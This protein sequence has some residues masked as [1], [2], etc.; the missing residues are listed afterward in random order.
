MK[1]VKY[2]N[3]FKYPPEF[4]DI[5]SFF[6]KK[7]SKK[8]LRIALSVLEHKKELIYSKK[9]DRY[10]PVEYSILSFTK[11]KKTSGNKLNNWRFRLY[12]RLISHLPQVKLVGL[13]GSIS[14]MNA[15]Q[16][17][18]VDLF[19]ITSRSRLFTAR[20]IL[21]LIAQLLWLRRT[22]QSNGIG[23]VC[24]NLFFDESDLAVPSFK[25]S[26]FVGH[27]VLQMKPIIDKDRTYERFIAANKWV[28]KLFPN[29]PRPEE[30]RGRGRKKRSF[31][32]D[33][34][35]AE[36]KKL[37]LRLI[38]RHRTTENITDTQ[39]WFHPD[40]FEKKISK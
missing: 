29:A 32:G 5:Y 16:N 17:D 21:L 19:V 40:D 25:Q 28:F 39:L 14:M 30:S 3:F 12:L 33:L 31:I 6:P 10:T 22:R 27:E 9:T 26:E 2:F 35:E 1:T 11:R 37:Q 7:T 34:I 36:L 18:D 24:L 23:K 13:S 4:E 15:K 8:A 38:N 20:F